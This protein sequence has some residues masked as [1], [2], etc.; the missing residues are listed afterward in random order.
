MKLY[1][2][3]KNNKIKRLALMGGTFD[4]IHYGHMVTAEAARSQFNLDKVIFVPT[5]YPPHKKNKN[6]SD[7]KHRFLMTVLAITTNP[8][9]EASRFE[10]EKSIYS[11]TIDTVNYFVNLYGSKVKL[12]FITG[13]DAVMEILTWKS[14]EELTRLCNFIAATRPGYELEQLDSTLKKLPE[15]SR[16]SFRKFEVPA[17]AISSTDIRNRVKNNKPIKYLVPETVEYYIY[18]NNL[19]CS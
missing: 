1:E 12:Y 6:I 2:E 3:K 18:K 19:Y 15:E 17:L 7:A 14:V 9:F 16:K 4:P 11:Y 8:Y 5:G 10:V 13:A